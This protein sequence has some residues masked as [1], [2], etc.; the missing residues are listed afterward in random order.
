MPPLL[1]VPCR[2]V[3]YQRKVHLGQKGAWWEIPLDV[4]AG[5]TYSGA[6][7]LVLV[8]LGGGRGWQWWEGGRKNYMYAWER[9][10]LAWG[11]SAAMRGGHTAEQASG[12][13]TCTRCSRSLCGA[14]CALR[15]RPS[16]QQAL[17]AVAVPA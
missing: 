5:A 11:A 8:P 9:C 6:F 4:K 2:W 10:A 13:C 15:S 3:A 12:V 14:A 7:R 1:A 16:H 17:P